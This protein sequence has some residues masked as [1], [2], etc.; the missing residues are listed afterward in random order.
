M[1]WR[2]RRPGGPRPGVWLV[3]FTNPVGIVTQALLD[4]GHRAIGLCNVAIGF[5][6]QFAARLGVTPD[7]VEL[8]HVG[9]NHLTWI[10]AVRV[11]GVDRLP[12]L[13]DA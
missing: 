8:E 2:R 6:R 11:D 13:L 12:E 7:Q 10:R 5:Q 9:L 3:D 1:A 4:D